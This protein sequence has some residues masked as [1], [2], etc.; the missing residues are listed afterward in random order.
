M[1]KKWWT[2]LAVCAGTFMLLLDVTIVIVAQPNPEW[3]YAGRVGGQRLLL[4]ISAH[5]FSL[6]DSPTRLMVGETTESQHPRL[7]LNK[8]WEV[9]VVPNY[10]DARY[11]LMNATNIRGCLINQERAIT[12]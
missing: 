2:L 6:A 5:R 8:K 10:F 7:Y 1:D 4:G 9:L 11:A 3:R 12:V